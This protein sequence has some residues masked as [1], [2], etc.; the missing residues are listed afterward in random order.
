M[1][2]ERPRNKGKK[3]ASRERKEMKDGGATAGSSHLW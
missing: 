1:S 3:H 2:E